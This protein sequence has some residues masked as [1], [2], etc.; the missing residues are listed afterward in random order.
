M[1]ITRLRRWADDALSQDTYGDRHV[2][3]TAG[4]A[5]RPASPYV[6]EDPVD[7]PPRHH[8]V[9]GR[10]RDLAACSSGRRLPSSVTYS[11]RRRCSPCMTGPAGT[12]PVTL[13]TT[14]YVPKSAS[15]AHPVPA[16]LLAHGFGGTKD[17]V[18]D[19]GQGPGQPRLR[20]AD[21]DRR[22]LRSQRRP[23]P[24]GQPGLGGQGRLPADRLAGR[25]AGDRA[26]T[27]PGDPRVAAVGGSYGGG[28]SLLLA[29]YDQRVDAIVPMITWNDLANAFLPDATGGGAAD[30]V[31]KKAWAGL[32]FGEQRLD[33][34][35][36]ARQRDPA[37]DAPT[38]RATRPAAASPADVC[39][40]LP[41]DR[42]RPAR[43]HR[44]TLALLRPVQP[45]QRARPDHRADA[46]HPGRG[47]LAV[48]AVRGRR[49]RAGHRR[50]TA[51]RCGSPGSPAATTAAPGRSPTRTG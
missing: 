38:G 40:R 47:R 3:S 7:P 27:A 25:P 19:A 16:V 5:A 44:P 22:G 30:G 20:G 29:G 9:G 24:P 51:R 6:A 1:D 2:I 12:T 23:D 35:R 50:D 10:R 45:G 15:A 11:T 41:V 17:S 37:G 4:S 13:D 33:V 34:D 8:L 48:P 42:H 39:A 46:A 26:R 28:F 32:F 18:A 14:F 49:E 31:F 43:R 21:L 36:A